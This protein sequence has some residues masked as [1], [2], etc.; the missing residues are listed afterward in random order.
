MERIIIAIL[1]E[2][3]KRQPDDFIIGIN[4]VQLSMLETLPLVRGEIRRI[5]AETGQKLTKREAEEYIKLREDLLG[6]GK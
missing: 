1:K 4:R 2:A 5:E 3:L 6:G